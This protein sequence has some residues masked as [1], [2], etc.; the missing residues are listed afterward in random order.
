MSNSKPCE[1]FLRSTY[2]GRGKPDVVELCGD[3]SSGKHAGQHY[4]QKH[5][6]IHVSGHAEWEEYGQGSDFNQDTDY[7]GEDFEEDIVV[8][9]DEEV[10]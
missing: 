9:D 3:P 1:H 10:I 8:D 2:E 7:G 6:H 5:L 4:C